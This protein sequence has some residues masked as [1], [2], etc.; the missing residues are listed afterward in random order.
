ML[1]FHRKFISPMR[2]CILILIFFL[3]Q[4]AS[5]EKTSFN[6]SIGQKTEAIKVQKSV[7]QRISSTFSRI[8]DSLASSLKNKP[9]KV[10]RHRCI[11]KI[12][13]KP[14][15]KYQNRKQ[16]IYD[17]M[18]FTTYVIENGKKQKKWDCIGLRE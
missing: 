11:W 13:S 15:K 10:T 16:T 7:F 5:P 18:C 6:K 1:S 17:R 2:L 14:L 9:E 3:V 4:F 12:C 8:V